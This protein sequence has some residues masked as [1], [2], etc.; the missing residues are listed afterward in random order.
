MRAVSFVD[1][2]EFDFVG[3]FNKNA[4]C[5]G[6]V[7]NDGLSE[8]C[9]GSITGELGVFKGDGPSPIYKDSELGIISCV[10]VGDIFNTGQNK[11]VVITA[12]GWTHVYDVPKIQEPL[13]TTVR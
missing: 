3:N 9:I 13:D 4:I 6:D 5:L 11:L 10:E 2:L 12:E 7:D 1:K 8:L